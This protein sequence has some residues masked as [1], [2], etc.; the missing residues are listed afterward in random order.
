GASALLAPER[1][2]AG[3]RRESCTPGTRGVMRENASDKNRVR[4]HMGGAEVLVEV[5]DLAGLAEGAGEAAS[6][7]IRGKKTVGA[8]HAAPLQIQGSSRVLDVRGQTAEEAQE[9]VVACL[10][11]AALAGAQTVRIIH[12]HGTGRLKQAL[13]DY[14]KTSPYVASFR[15]G[16]RAE[17]GDGVTVV[18]VK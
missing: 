9:A 12:G 6:Q 16:E 2:R 10:D 18:N 13:R 15:P 14:L 1:A 8:Q 3:A 17:G 11:R 4:I 7:E 5:S